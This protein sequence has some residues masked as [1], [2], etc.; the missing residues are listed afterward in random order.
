MEMDR[1]DELLLLTALSGEIPADWIGRAI[2]SESYAAALLTRLKREGEVKLRSRDGIRGY[3]LRSKAKQYLLAHYP[4]DVRA[5]L[6]GASSTNHV[7]SEPDKR[8]RLHRMSMVWIYFHRAGIRIFHSEKPEL[9]P[10]FHQAP[11]DTTAIQ[12]STISAYYGTM[13]W[14]RET[15]ME[16][17]GSRACGVLEADCFYVVYNTMDCLMKWVPKTERNVRSR[18]EVRLRKNRGTLPGGAVIMGTDMEMVK[19]ILISDGGLKGNLFSLDDVFESYYYIPFLPEAVIQLKLLGSEAGE[20]R[21]YQ[22]LC[23]ALKRV[24]EDC[25]A[26]EA[27]KDENGNPVYFC[28]L[29][30]LW[31]LKRIISLPLK[32]GGRI[33]CFTYQAEVLRSI[34]PECFKVE[35]IRPEKVYRYLGWK[36]QD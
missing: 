35:A 17:K 16:I 15:D 20:K 29:M 18:L 13:E 19:R 28:Y 33:F 6:S 10:A 11:S 14:K 21:F 7:K 2:G 31:K 5:Y 30:E 23:S 1:R 8:L 27:G 4:D 34:V 12:D 36:N 3:L 22:F 25:F 32:R 24:N 26:P 9:F